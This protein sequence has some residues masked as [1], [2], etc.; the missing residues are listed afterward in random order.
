MEVSSS[1][2]LL[3]LITMAP[4]CQFGTNLCQTDRNPFQS[5][6]YLSFVV[7]GMGNTIPFVYSASSL[8]R[9]APL[10]AVPLCCPEARRRRRVKRIIHPEHMRQLMQARMPPR[11]CNVSGAFLVEIRRFQA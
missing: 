6:Y 7:K 3:S 8:Y 9:E 4:S 5:P 10:I 11:V 1:T 2:K